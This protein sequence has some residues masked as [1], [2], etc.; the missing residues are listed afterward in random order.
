MVIIH[1]INTCH[2]TFL[3]YSEKLKTLKYLA[4]H[5]Q[6][7]NPQQLAK[8]LDVSERTVERMVQRLRDNGFPIKYNRLRCT[9][10]VSV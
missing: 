6:T 5:K 4:E 7:G 9:Y 3:E 1:Q 8:K 2:M 10:E